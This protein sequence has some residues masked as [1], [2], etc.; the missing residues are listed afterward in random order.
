[1]AATWT[2]LGQLRPAIPKVWNPEALDAMTLP[3]VGLD[4]R[5][6]Y[7]AAEWYYRIPEREIY[8]GYPVYDLRKEP[9]GYMEWL[10]HQNPEMPVDPSKLNTEFDWIQA[11]ESVYSSVQVDG[12]LTPDDLHN[13]AAWEKFRFVA[14][15][16]GSLPGWRYVIRK[17]GLIEVGPTLCGSCH[18]RVVEGATVQGAPGTA[19]IGVETAY[20]IRR[21]LNAAPSWDV[22]GAKEV[23]RQLGLFSVPWLTP[24][25]AG[26]LAEMSPGQILTAYDT[27]PSGVV[28]RTGTSLFFPPRIPDL[29]GIKD[30]KYLG[31]T[32]L[33]RHL[34]IGDLM[35]Y[36]ALEAGMDDYTQYGESRPM[37]ET[38]DPAGLS[39]LS[40]TQLYALALYLYSL[41][42]PANPNRIDVSA[43][44]GQK[45]FEREGCAECHPAP[46]YTNNQLLTVARAASDPR[47]TT[48]TRK[49]TGSYAVPSLRGVWYREPLEHNGSF[50]MLEDWFD[51]TRLRNNY[52]PTGFK[53]YGVENRAV[54]GHLFGLTL[55][56]DERRSLGSFL[57]TL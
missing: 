21:S 4:K 26:Q 52:V 32:G 31:A 15:A 23:A 2:C 40:D 51:P 19:L 38:P 55:S 35:R 16:E 6:K 11:G 43:K 33:H 24:D 18:E 5:I 12:L 56:F 37:G 1:M 41:K 14:D 30:R 34:G 48:Q 17:R 8:R 13:P 22:A 47:L 3:L 25:P 45:I 53:G 49:A 36:A 20:R 10:T 28:A 42:A 9:R 39:R 7:P 29:I 27:M 50:A 46:L 54:K 44:R 57:R